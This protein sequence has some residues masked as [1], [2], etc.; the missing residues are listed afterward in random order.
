MS[1]EVEA[2]LGAEEFKSA[3]RH[4][5]AGVTVVTATAPAGPVALTVSSVTS[6]SAEP[7]MLLFSVSDSTR[8][9]SAL[10]QAESV[11]VHL[12]GEDDH[13]LAVLCADPSAERFA[14]TSQWGTLPTG[15]PAFH[16]P[17]ILLRG[18]VTQRIRSGHAIVLMLRVVD[19][20]DRRSEGRPKAPKPLVYHDRRWY[21]LSERSRIG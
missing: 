19:M 5:A 15:E 16:G 8:T 21:A 14:D 9:G 11:I 3:F 18:S 20:I 7:P 6:V 13:P 1:A 12:L 4:H 17:R 10:A 2:S